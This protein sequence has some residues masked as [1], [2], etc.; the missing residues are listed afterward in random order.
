MAFKGSAFLRLS[1]LSNY[2]PV[3]RWTDQW[4]LEYLSHC[5][6]VSDVRPLE[7]KQSEAIVVGARKL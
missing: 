5:E 2:G 4:I 1:G 6:A 7:L 3:N